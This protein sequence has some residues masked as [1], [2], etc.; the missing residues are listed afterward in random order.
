M[1]GVMSGAE[2][3]TLGGRI[4]VSA[5]RNIAAEWPF[6][7]A[8]GVALAFAIGADLFQRRDVIRK[9]TGRGVRT[10]ALYAV[11]ELC[12][13]QALLV[14][15]P[16][17]AALNS[18]VRTYLPWLHFDGLTTLPVWVQVV[19]LLILADFWQYWCHRLKHANPY[20]WQFHKIHHSQRE[21]TVLTRFR[22]PILDRLLSLV[23]VVPLGAITGSETLPLALYILVALRSCLEHSGLNWTFGPL[24]RLIVSPSFH[25]VH[26]SVAPEHI[27]RNF[28]GFL[29]VW[30]YLFHTSAARGDRPLAYGLAHEEIPECFVRQHWLPITGIWALLQRKRIAPVPGATA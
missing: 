26:H 25:A 1:S 28:G 7:A 23:L 17:S 9:W 4:I 14:L 5:V 21:L 30:D 13:L 18:I 12:H 15:V 11:A 29:S 8:L 10:D 6:Y 3:L 20:L 2:M 16:A 24:G 22:F 19:V 27:N